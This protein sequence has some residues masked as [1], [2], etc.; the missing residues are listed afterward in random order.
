M[1]KTI[2][3]VEI[4]SK[5]KFGA[6][7][8][9]KLDNVCCGSLCLT[10]DVLFEDCFDKDDQN[11]WETSTLREKLMKVIEDYIDKSALVPFDR[12]L[13]TDDGQLKY[14]SCTDVVSLLTCNEY[15]KYRE[16]IP[17]CG[18]WYWTITADSIKYLCSIRY[19]T[20]DSIRYITPGGSLLSEH[21]FICYGGVRPL[22]VLKSDTVVEV[23]E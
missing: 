6:I 21:A 20:P 17:N 4:G 11:N 22:C 9:V 8:F 18:K 12:D 19:I 10:T 7:E 2:K 13:T 23:E 16:F 15:R 14:G 5:F 1:K 3:D